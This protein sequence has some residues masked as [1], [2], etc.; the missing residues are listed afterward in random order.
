MPQTSLLLCTAQ[1]R[2][3]DRLNQQIEGGFLGV[4]A[5]LLK[6]RALVIVTRDTG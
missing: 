6:L 1:L 4:L 5:P 3:T 2:H